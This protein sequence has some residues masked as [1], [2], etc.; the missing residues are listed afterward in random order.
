M[1]AILPEA[2]TAQQA[3]F[4]MPVGGQASAL[5]PYGPV[6]R[7]PHPQTPCPSSPAGITCHFCR[8]KKLCGEA[9]CRR[10]AFR[11]SSQDCIGKTNCS[12]CQSATGRFCRACLSIRYVRVRVVVIWWC[13]G[14]G[15]LQ[16]VTE[17]ASKASN[18]ANWGGINKCSLCKV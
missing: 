13:G 15:E 3:T 11:D 8:Q 10:C 1:F 6:S 12:R 2:E 14:R 5:Q 4:S 16:V 7:V 9:D 18:C 17:Q